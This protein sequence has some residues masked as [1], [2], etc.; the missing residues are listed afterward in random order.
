MEK[1]FQEHE[2]TI[3]FNGEKLLIKTGKL[4][5]RAESTAWVQI[6]GTVVL[7][8][9]SMSEKESTLDYFPL[10]VEYVEKFYAGGIISG[11]RFVKRERRPSDE[12][13]L[14]ARQIDHSI[15]S[16]FPKSFKREVNVIITVMSYDGE[17]DPETLAVLSSSMALMLSS[18]PFDGPSSSVKVGI[19]ADK[20]ILNPSKKEKE[21]DSDFIVSVR[22]KRVLNIEGY[23][24]EVSEEKMGELLDFAVE[25]I[26]PLQ[27]M[28]RKFAKEFG[29]PKFEV[30]ELPAPEDLIK[31]VK[32]DYSD[33]VKTGLYDQDM[34][35]KIFAD[36]VDEMIAADET[37]IKHEVETAVDYVAMKMM[38]E[39]VLKD[40]KRTSGRKLDEFRELAIETGLLP[41]VHGSALFRRGITQ[42]L[43]IL[44]LASPKFAMTMESYMGEEEKR[45]MHHY[46]GPD[47]SLGEAG[48]FNYYPGRRE[49]GHGFIGENALMKV[50]PSF[51]EFPYTIRV[52]SE[53]LSQRGS[54][55]MASTCGTSLAL[56]DA[57]VP[58][59]AQVGGISVGLVTAEGDLET[60]KLL[61]DIEDVE[62]F[63]GD[64]DFKVTGTTKG[65]TAI[66]LDN[67]LKGVPVIILK[68]AF[69]KSK[70]A[71][72]KIIEAMNE[73]ISEPR[74]QLSEFAPKIES[75]HINK[76]RI[77]ELIGPGGKNIKALMEKID[78]DEQ[79]LDIE[80]EDDG[81]VI[82]SSMN[83][84]KIELAK[85]EIMG[86][87]EEPEIGKEYS[88][89]VDKVT[90][91][92]AFVDVN[93][94]IS[95]L[96]HVSEMSDTFVKDPNDV[97]KEGQVVK[98]KI[99][100]LEG[101]RISFTMK[102]VNQK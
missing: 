2:S 14:V 94:S 66:Q 43:S 91:Y 51:E 42:A 31:K 64:M 70:A 21:L 23:G 60:F 81:T 3:D 67:K 63:Y 79:Q 13:V 8:I 59:K 44:T 77:G 38:R 18:I 41:R 98:V 74:K 46:N 95:G 76:N 33:K 49:I 15:R 20:F 97:V 48:R 100:K 54:S 11:S 93:A 69:Q 92:G 30:A 88:G 25:A 84:S 10:T 85:A 7:A 55:S 52:V 62:D 61:V 37:L 17:H 82:I 50:L 71:R 89:V 19:K 87:M 58:I 22:E 1:K 57:G 9:V 24:N 102:G 6:G 101:D 56:M 26:E 99:I 90:N 12:A 80:I 36:V 39:A 65:V 5:P 35:N 45:F 86:M 4:A 72:L 73:V 34:R 53:V 68:E 28:Q 83:Q 32:S 78:K 96:L 40:E 16:L 47:Y 75:V 29:K 27:D